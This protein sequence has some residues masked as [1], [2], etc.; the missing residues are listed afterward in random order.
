MYVF[1]QNTTKNQHAAK[2]DCNTG[3]KADAHAFEQ[4]MHIYI[5]MHVHIC[6]GTTI[7]GAGRTR[8]HGCM[9]L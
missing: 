1:N 7:D 6:A 9:Q 3:F 8:T 4:C 2:P 5:Y